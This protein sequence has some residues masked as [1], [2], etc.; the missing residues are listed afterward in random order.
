MRGQPNHPCAEIGL[1][2]VPFHFLICMQRTCILSES[3]QKNHLDIVRAEGLE[4][5]GSLRGNIS[6]IVD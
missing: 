2:Y 4:K 5:R 6:S 1:G 3:L